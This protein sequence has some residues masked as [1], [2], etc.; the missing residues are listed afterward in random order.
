MLG[1]DSSEIASELQRLAKSGVES[2]H[3][4]YVPDAIA[5]ERARNQPIENPV[6]LVWTGPES[7]QSATRDT[8]VVVRE[9][10]AEIAEDWFQSKTDRRPSHVS[11]LRTR[12]DKHILPMFGTDK[13][14]RITA[15]AVEKFRND[16]RDQD[17]A[18]RTIN[19]ILRIMGA[20]FRL[21]IKRGQCAKNPV[22]SVDRAVETA[23]EIKRGEEYTDTGNDAV[24]PESILSPREIQTLLA[25]AQPVFQRVLYET[26]YLTGAR[27]GELLA[28]R[29]LSWA[30][31][32][33]EETRPRY[34]PPKTKAG[35]RTIS[36]PA[37][38]VNDLKKWKLRCP[39]SEE[40][41][42]F[43][44]TEGKPVCRDALLRVSF[45]PALSRAR[46]R[47]VTFH[48]LRHSCASAMIAVG[49]PITEVQHRLGHA[50]PAITLQIYIYSHFL[51][52]TESAVADRLADFVLQNM[53]SPT[54]TGKCGH[55][56]GTQGG[57]AVVEIPVSA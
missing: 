5:A 14:D 15:A 52:P 28:L 27:E 20:L 41:L 31:L 17:C 7:I 38:L 57:K 19:T 37:L 43:P 42:V 6:E 4:A 47:R 18:R 24:D 13:L 9:T 23:K 29:S 40:N 32:K 12:L 39:N 10:F 55:F 16:L 35:R 51:S 30:R 44:T 26:A 46:L 22:D 3:I 34:F 1:A 21:A 48:T 36:I 54:E 8:G 2:A 49:A 11:D 33:G 53:E 50:N 25:A 45:Y 56:V